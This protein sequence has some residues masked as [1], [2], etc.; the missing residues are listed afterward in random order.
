VTQRYGQDAENPSYTLRQYSTAIAS[1]SLRLDNA[2]RL[3][4]VPMKTLRPKVRLQH[5]DGGEHGMP[6]LWVQKEAF[7]TDLWRRKSP[8]L[9]CESRLGSSIRVQGVLCHSAQLYV[10]AP[11]HLLTL[12]FRSRCKHVVTLSNSIQAI[13]V[14]AGQMTAACLFY[15]EPTGTVQL[16]ARRLAQF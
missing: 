14:S 3:L 6:S 1:P 2:A 10:P 8:T 12:A 15:G 11:L 7:V 9:P 13:L 16:Q 4:D 5:L